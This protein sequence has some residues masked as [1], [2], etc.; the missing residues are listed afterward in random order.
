MPGL[1]LSQRL[2]HTVLHNYY[3]STHQVKFNI[4]KIIILYYYEIGNC[5]YPPVTCDL[6]VFLFA[7]RPSG[8]GWEPESV[9]GQESCSK[10]VGE[11]VHQNWRIL[12]ATRTVSVVGLFTLLQQAWQL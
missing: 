6:G 12:C 9:N 10:I 1:G 8:W 2:L 7:A 5:Y 3:Y 11:V 4:E